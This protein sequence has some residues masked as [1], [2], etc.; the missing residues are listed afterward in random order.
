MDDDERRDISKWRGKNLLGFALM[1]VREHLTRG[2]FFCQLF[3]S[4][5]QATVRPSSD[6]VCPVHPLRCTGRS[7]PA[8]RSAYPRYASIFGSRVRLAC[9]FFSSRS[10]TAPYFSLLILFFC[11]VLRY[12]I[13]TVRE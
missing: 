12:H 6:Y 3:L 10:I 11:S 4:E 7:V 8:V 1:E 2:R 9:L 13:T 5:A